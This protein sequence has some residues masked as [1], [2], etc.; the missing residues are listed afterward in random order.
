MFF[1]LFFQL[2][3]G[4]KKKFFFSSSFRL[5]QRGFGPTDSR[6]L[7]QRGLSSLQERKGLSC[8]TPTLPEASQPGNQRP[9]PTYPWAHRLPEN[10]LVHTGCSRS[11]PDPVTPG[12]VGGRPWPVQ[13]PPAPP[14]GPGT[15]PG[16]CG[17]WSGRTLRESPVWGPPR[18]LHHI[19]TQAQQG[20]P[21]HL[22]NFPKQA[23][24]KA[25]VGPG[26]SGK[27]RQGTH[28]RP[29]RPPEHITFRD[30]EVFPL[31]FQMLWDLFCP[32][33]IQGNAGTLQHWRSLQIFFFLMHSEKYFREDWRNFNMD[34]VF[35]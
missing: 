17:W 23:E 21:I 11:V 4:F 15:G 30:T 34:F 26:G 29:P 8:P 2:F 20:P 10:L 27:G 24:G 12:L 22:V 16:M 18:P 32:N 25:P 9:R 14:P 33:E 6:L 1:K 31:M 3:C 35:P 5:S 13:L 19:N 7:W 28:S